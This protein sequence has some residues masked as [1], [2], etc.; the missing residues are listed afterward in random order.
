MFIK[1]LKI[2]NGKKN[3]YYLSDFSINYCEIRTADVT[4]KES[5]TGKNA[6]GGVFY[7]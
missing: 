6:V 1:L 4:Q 7:Q 2:K 3:F 5:V